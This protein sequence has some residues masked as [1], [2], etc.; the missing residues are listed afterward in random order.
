VLARLKSLYGDLYTEQNVMLSGSHTHSTPGGYM[1]NLLF[2]LSILGFVRQTFVALMAGI[3]IVSCILHH[4]KTW[5]ILEIPTGRECRSNKTGIVI[6]VWLRLETIVTNSTIKNKIIL[7]YECLLDCNAVHFGEGPTFRMNTSP[8]I[9]GLW[10][11]FL[12]FF[13]PWTPLIVW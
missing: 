12:I 3:V 13:V 9:R 11:G 10:P 5:I 6:F 2:D 8:P 4:K 1:Q 7:R